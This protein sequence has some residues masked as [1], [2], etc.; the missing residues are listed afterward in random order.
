MLISFDKAF[1]G[2]IAFMAEQT[3]KITDNIVKWFSIGG[4]A[5]AKINPG[6]LKNTI[7]PVLEML[8]VLHDGMVDI[9]LLKVAFD[10]AF[11]A[12]P[13]ITYRKFV[14]NKDDACGLVAKLREIASAEMRQTQMTASGTEVG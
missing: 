13:E 6:P 2:L 1:D 8:S 7:R 4:L 3:S 9:D 14:F 10:E 12:V 11:K 5:V